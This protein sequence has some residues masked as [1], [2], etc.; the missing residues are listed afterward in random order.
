MNAKYLAL[1]LILFLIPTLFAGSG[2]R[3]STVIQG[4]ETL[5]EEK[6]LPLLPILMGILMLSAAVIYALGQA[7]GAEMRARTS[8]WATSLM[9]SVIITAILYLVLSWMV[10][11]DVLQTVIPEHFRTY[12]PYLGFSLMF[13]IGLLIFFYLIAAIFQHPP[14]DA[15]KQEELAAFILTFLIVVGWGFLDASMA[16]VTQN[17]ICAANGDLCSNISIAGASGGGFQSHVSLAY[18]ALNVLFVKLRDIYVNLYLFEVLIG[19][20][21][22]I[23]FPIG[24]LLPGLNII[25]FTFMPFDGLVLLSNAH[26]VVVEAIGYTMMVI[27]AK[28]NLLEFAE[29][30]VPLVLLPIGLILRAFPWYR[31]T[32]SSLI[33]IC[34]VL[35]FVYPLS[36]LLSNYLIFDAYKPANFAYAPT[37]AEVA[38]FSGQERTEAE[39]REYIESKNEEAEDMLHVF[40]EGGAIRASV[41]E[42]CGTGLR[43]LWCDI[44]NFFSGIWTA[45]T[46]LVHTVW[47]IGKAMWTF[48]GDMLRSI[49]HGFLP[50]GATGGL[51]TFIVWEVVGVSQFIVL[52][53]FTSVLEIIITVTSYRNIA[54]LI[55]G[56]IEIAGLAKLV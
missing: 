43:G 49:L 55:G 33:T 45:V 25:S 31:G 48:G 23:S 6:V 34:V 8:V 13:A 46:G 20:L 5:V 53:L 52:V 26:T 56:E 3:G 27:I 50:S 16:N 11:P 30:A 17:L 44:K 10:R 14:L 42:A 1:L 29:H 7:L 54:S 36:V 21:S 12:I 2:P 47:T 28:Q 9:Y 24:S 37:V 39:M 40:Q 22:T 35:Y 19:F 51:Y 18:S 32:G 4:L 41:Q 15:I 38:G